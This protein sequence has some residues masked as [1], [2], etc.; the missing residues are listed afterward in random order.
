MHWLV[1]ILFSFLTKLTEPSPLHILPYKIHQ[2]QVISWASS[3]P[4][5]LWERALPRLTI[6][7]IDETEHKCVQAGSFPDL[8]DCSRFYTCNSIE[9][10]LMGF[11]FSCPPSLLYNST[12]ELCD[13][14]ERV[15]CFTVGSD[16]PTHDDDDAAASRSGLFEDNIVII[17][18]ADEYECPGEGSYPVNTSC[19]FYY[20]CAL[21]DG[22]LQAEEVSCPPDMLFN[23][24][25]A[26]CEAATSFS[27]SL[28]SMEDIC[29]ASTLTQEEKELCNSNAWKHTDQFLLL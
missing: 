11:T 1:I 18:I 17:D 14:P 3:T 27:C 25:T 15:E 19:A 16:F 6:L 7:P 22:A 5:V 12:A 8:Y 29:S 2:N 20:S 28:S 23:S 26:S 10:K 4:G 21:V 13:W 9:G 24:A